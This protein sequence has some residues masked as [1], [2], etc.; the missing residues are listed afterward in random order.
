MRFTEKVLVL[1]AFYGCYSQRTHRPQGLVLLVIA[2][3]GLFL[4]YALGGAFLNNGIPARRIFRTDSY[5]HL[6]G[7]MLAVGAIAGLFQ[8]LFL[9][10]VLFKLQHWPGAMLFRSTSVI[11]SLLVI[12]ALALARRTGKPLFSNLLIRTVGLGVFWVAMYVL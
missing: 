9:V 8:A 12:L 5:A 11:A 2:L 4:L 10:G 3:I 6:Q 7:W 1:F